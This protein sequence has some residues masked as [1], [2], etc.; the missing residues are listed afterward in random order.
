MDENGVPRCEAEG[1][2]NIGKEVDH[3]SPWEIELEHKLDNLFLL[4]KECHKAKTAKDLPVI[5]KVLRLAGERV[6]TKK[7]R[8]IPGRPFQKVKKAWPKKPKKIP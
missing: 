1:C 5:H 8:P 6:S 3:F 2:N 7:K 4:C